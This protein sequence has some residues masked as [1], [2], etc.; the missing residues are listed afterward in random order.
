MVTSNK[1]IADGVF[2]ANKLNS[3]CV[4][5]HGDVISEAM[6]NGCNSDYGF[7]HSRY[8]F[9]DKVT[10]TYT[11]INS[12]CRIQN[13]SAESVKTHTVAKDKSPGDNMSNNGSIIPNVRSLLARDLSLKLSYENTGTEVNLTDVSDGKNFL[14]PDSN[15]NEMDCFDQ[16]NQIEPDRKRTKIIRQLK[17]KNTNYSFAPPPK[18]PRLD[19]HTAD[20]PRYSVDT[21]QKNCS[22]ELSK[23]DLKFCLDP[24]ESG[25]FGLGQPRTFL[26]GIQ[27]CSVPLESSSLYENRS[28]P[29]CCTVGS[30]V[31]QS[32]DLS[33]PT[34]SPPTTSSQLALTSTIA[35][36]VLDGKE[37]GGAVTQLLASRTEQ[38]DK[39]IDE[40]ML[41]GYEEDNISPDS[42]TEENIL[43][44]IDDI[45]N[46]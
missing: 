22:S 43:L 27:Q 18:R 45:L 1:D 40:E 32:I 9:G 3:G 42:E 29:S 4:A 7:Q 37:E 11:K 6:Q 28:N 20:S 19:P 5:E 39:D 23:K 46:D 17:R 8:V 26:N 12:E 13:T 10:V 35:I 34:T 33:S 36:C 2:S 44:Q 14:M 25:C 38:E 31:A 21:A 41:L 16:T 15:I 30:V 24:G